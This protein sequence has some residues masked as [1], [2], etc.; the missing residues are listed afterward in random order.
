MTAR[1]IADIFEQI[2][3]IESGIAGDELGFVFGDPN[4]EVTS[5]AC[6]WQVHTPCLEAA[7]RAG[8]NFLL[9]HES[10][11][12]PEQTSPWY[13][14]PGREQIFANRE[15]RRLLEA[16][17]ITVYRSHSNWD[18][19]QGDGVPD[20]AVAALAIEGLEVV[21]Q[22]KFFKVHRLPAPL[23]VAGLAAKVKQGFVISPRVFGD[24]SKSISQFAFL[25]GGFGENQWH[26]P[27]A[28]FELGAEAII[29]G[30]MSE[31]IVSASLEIGM[32]VIETLHSMSESP[33]I[34]RQAQM[35]SDRLPGVDVH[36]IVSGALSWGH[37]V[38]AVLVK[39]SK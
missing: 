7:A 31:F 18:A 34:F 4:V 25:I 12:L 39:G 5:M 28:A 24:A 29:I 32:P 20:Q 37:N 21:T 1:Q 35:L 19:L 36:F 9:C 22:Q 14:G 27:Q 17:G 15:R 23:T 6:V 26:M 30:E 10:I 2:A 16:H 3:P 13:F 38:S 11:W 33:A 8:I